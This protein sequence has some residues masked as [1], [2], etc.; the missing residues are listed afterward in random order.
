[1]LCGTFDKY[2]FCLLWG[3]DIKKSRY[4]M[5]SDNTKMYLIALRNGDTKIISRKLYV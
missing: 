1:M 2:N 3:L 5:D 4:I